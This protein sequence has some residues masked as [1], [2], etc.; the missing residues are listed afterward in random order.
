[1][2]KKMCRVEST[3]LGND[4]HGFELDVHVTYPG[5]SA[6]GYQVH[7]GSR[8]DGYHEFLHAIIVNLLAVFHRDSWEKLKGAA[9]YALIDKNNYIAGFQSLE[10]DGDE[11]FT[12]N[13]IG[14]K[15]IRP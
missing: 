10:V 3:F 14:E 2:E 7:I 1:M 8:I 9:A 6:Q 13:E 15:Y 4:D 12:T 5:H 11:Q